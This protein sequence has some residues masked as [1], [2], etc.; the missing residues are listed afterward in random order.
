M[1]ANI[2][3]R[4]TSNEMLNGKDVPSSHPA[5]PAGHL[6]MPSDALDSA[7]LRVPP[8]TGKP[9][10]Q[11]GILEASPKSLTGCDTPLLNRSPHPLVSKGTSAKEDS[12]FSLH[13][14]C[15]G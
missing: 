6:G 12:I 1:N 7:V 4:E 9:W 11:L 15:R 10:A 2:P 5:V 13:V 3:H 8:A 14:G